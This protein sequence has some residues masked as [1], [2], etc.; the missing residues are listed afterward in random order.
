[1]WSNSHLLRESENQA[2]TRLITKLDPS[3]TWVHSSSKAKTTKIKSPKKEKLGKKTG[4][5]NNKAKEVQT[6]AS[7]GVGEEK[8][9]V[10][11]ELELLLGDDPVL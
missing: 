6:L 11:A 2:G 7:L 3:I 8:L 1:M 10:M 5:F 9:E 4:L